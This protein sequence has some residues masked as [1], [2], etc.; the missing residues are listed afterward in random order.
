MQGSEL[1][2]LPADLEAQ[3]RAE[4]LGDGN[5]PIGVQGIHG[6]NPYTSWKHRPSLGPHR[7][8]ERLAPHVE[9]EGREVEDG[10]RSR[11]DHG[12]TEQGVLEPEEP[13]ALDD[14]PG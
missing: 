2:L 8:F 1:R 3:E 11:V 7:H 13:G 10:P 9:V 12:D 14:P 6:T 5:V 4:G